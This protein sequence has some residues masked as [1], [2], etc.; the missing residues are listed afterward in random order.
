MANGSSSTDAVGLE[1]SVRKSCVSCVFFTVPTVIV[2]S[3]RCN[4]AEPVCARS[5]ST[6]D[7]SEVLTCHKRFSCSQPSAP[8]SLNH[9][10]CAAEIF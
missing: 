4:A 2:S 10:P 1:P 5:L 7:D 6:Q 8:L 3:T 9:P